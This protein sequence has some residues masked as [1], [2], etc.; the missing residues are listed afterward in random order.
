M[1]TQ[2]N[3]FVTNEDCFLIENAHIQFGHVSKNNRMYNISS[4][5][6]LSIRN[7]A[8]KVGFRCT[9]VFRFP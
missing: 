8:F 4:T 5:A 6:D 1:N 9:I 2:Q 3:F 7:L